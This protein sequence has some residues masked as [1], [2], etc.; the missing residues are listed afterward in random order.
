MAVLFSDDFAGSGALGANWALAQGT[1]LAR[2]SGDA[3][4]VTGGASRGNKI[5]GIS[6]PNDQ[7]AKAV[8]AQNKGSGRYASLFVRASGVD[9]S[10]VGYQISFGGTNEWYISLI[11]GADLANGTTTFN[12]GDTIEIRAV[13]T[14]ISIWLNGSMLSGGSVTDST[15]TS[16]VPGMA[17]Y[18]EGSAIGFASFESGDFGSGSTYSLTCEQGSYSL[19]GQ[20]AGLLFGHKLIAEQGTYTLLGSEAYVDI[21]MAMA[22]GS[23]ALSGQ[24]AALVADQ[25]GS[26]SLTADSGTYALTG[27][28]ATL[29]RTA[30]MAM[31][32]GSYA[33]SGQAIGL[34][35]SNAPPPVVG[36]VKTLRRF[37]GF[38][39]GR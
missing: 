22:Q 16:G 32:Q 38:R 26:V 15:H 4:D 24:D 2:V 17:T 23:Y 34:V 1:G 36:L 21:S 39:L 10:L 14:T 9:G 6:H 28:A 8:L 33:L 37:Y 31:A 11:G 19:S 20:T 3:Y 29:R 13:G 30:L 5:T 27:Q 18:W 35:W 25:D 7:Y 12:I